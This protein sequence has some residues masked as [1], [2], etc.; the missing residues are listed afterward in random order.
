MSLA[1]QRGFT[2]TELVVAMALGL[3][4]MMVLLAFLNRLLVTETRLLRGIRFEQELATMMSRMMADLRRAGYS[5]QAG[6]S[7]EAG[8]F[9]GLVQP[10]R[11]C[12]LYRYAHRSGG[13]SRP[14]A[15][16]YAGFRLERGRIQ[17]RTSLKG[18]PS[19]RCLDCRRGR[20]VSLNDAKDWRVTEL[21]FVLQQSAVGSL[22]VGITLRAEMPARP[23]LQRRL[24]SALIVP[25][26]GH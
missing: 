24:Q 7:G 15:A 16:D 20:W 22:H 26:Q 21:S 2:L 3:F 25:N 9:L 1:G 19:D 4:V 13:R 6:R 10:R 5:P 14:L 11:D 8:A 23:P 17:M 12:L 18:C